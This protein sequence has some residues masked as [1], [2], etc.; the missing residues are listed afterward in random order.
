MKIAIILLAIAFPLFA[1]TPAFKAIKED[2]RAKAAVVE[3]L[4][5]IILTDLNIRNLPLED[6]L[7]KLNNPRPRVINYVIRKPKVTRIADDAPFA[8]PPPKK[9]QPP[10]KLTL[11]SESLSFAKALDQLCQGADHLWAISFNDRGLPILIITPKL[12]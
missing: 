2:Y 1:E 4:D 5:K 12:N 6:A 10:K 3:K 11:V 9:I 7:S 8:G